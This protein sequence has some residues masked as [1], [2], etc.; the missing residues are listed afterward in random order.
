MS[1]FF[2]NIRALDFFGGGTDTHLSLLCQKYG[3]LIGR[4]WVQMFLF[5]NLD[6]WEGHLF[7]RLNLHLYFPH[8]ED[9]PIFGLNKRNM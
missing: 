2:Y 4:L 6:V 1:F 3:N 7:L 9:L 5:L 8:M